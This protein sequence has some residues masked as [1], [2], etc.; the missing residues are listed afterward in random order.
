MLVM[1]DLNIGQLLQD[2]KI[3]TGITS[4]FDMVLLGDEGVVNPKE[5]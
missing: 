4:I 1:V 5:V 2:F 3:L